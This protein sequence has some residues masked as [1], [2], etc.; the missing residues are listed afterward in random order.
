MRNHLEHD[1]GSEFRVVRA[2]RVQFRRNIGHG[3]RGRHGPASFN[4][5]GY[6]VKDFGLMNYRFSLKKARRW[7][8]EAP[9]APNAFRLMNNPGWREPNCQ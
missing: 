4:P 7:E 9:A 6:A 5:K 1:S 3:M 8:G 2:F